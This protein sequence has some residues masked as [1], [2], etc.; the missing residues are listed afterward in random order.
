MK[1]N[2]FI[3]RIL[4]SP[5]LLA[6]IPAVILIF[7][8]PPLG[9][10]Y[11]LITDDLGK[12][13]SSFHY[14]DLNSDGITEAINSGKGIPYYHLVI[15]NND[16][17][18]FDQWN[19]RDVLHPDLKGL[20]TG[21]IDNDRFMEI[22]VFTCKDDSL[23]LNVNEFFDPDGIRLER[24]FISKISVVNNT[25]TS[26]VYPAGF[27]DVTGDGYAEFYFSIQTGFGLEPRLCYYFD[28][29][30]K[31]L[32]SSQFSGTI[33]LNPQFVDA[34]GDN[35][36]ELFG[37]MSAS[38]NYKT[39]TPFTD[40]STWLMV[41]DER[42]NFEFQPV[43]FP[44][45]TNLLDIQYYQN[46][47]FKGYILSHNTGSA[48][49][50]VLKPRIMLY[51]LSGEKVKERVYAE[52][53]IR[54][55]T[56][57]FVL[58]HK[59]GNRIFVL[60]NE[61]IELNEDLE[62]IAREL[63]PFQQYYFAYA[64]D[65]DMD[66]DTEFLLYSNHENRLVVYNSKLQKLTETIINLPGHDTQFSHYKPADSKYKL[67][68]KSSENAYFLTLVKNDYY[69]LGYFLYPGIYLLLVFFIEVLN[70]ITTNRVQQKERLKQRL[71]TLQL[72]GIKAQLDP[73]FTFNSLNSIA[74]LIYL[75]ERDAAYDSLNKFTK[76]IRVMLSDAER[77]YR[78]LNE[79][80]E[81]V[82][83]Y[84]ELEKMR[85]GDKLTYDIKIGS[86]I[87]GD[88]KVPKLVLHTFAENAIK[89]GIMPGENGGML[90]ISV[91]KEAD[92]MKITIEDN[93]IGR[94]K[95]AGQSKSTGKGLKITGEFYDILNQLNDRQLS[96][97]IIDLYDKSGS[98][99]GT[100][101]EVLVPVD[102]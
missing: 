63:S 25:V 41:L 55:H 39:K 81:F 83:T 11:R 56:R 97:T 7:L 52:I 31:V 26:I 93:G 90:W 72:Q 50:S 5:W 6:S 10:K 102:Q 24:V 79:E 42:L 53:G 40:Q 48:D 18:V 22:F 94:E 82:T 28:V 64:E 75:E 66:G 86:G 100:R 71:L 49:T 84:L 21:D 13:Y 37:I 20:H 76:L 54:S 58:N 95:A 34:D 99:A 51:S 32:T 30:N 74:S 87:S 14:V 3:K 33:F 17:R 69:Y 27:Y 12:E 38:G 98:S 60:A 46:S 19:F 96:Y 23:F 67:Y 68:V 73:H 101:V 92:Y 8:L 2:S 91:Y 88:E 9:L 77:I 47:K 85:F 57:M 70:R 78:T 44:G 89:H 62:V 80:L 16:M 15:M 36:P 4:F 59:N 61:L 45:M 43:E 35:K 1:G 65:I 29:V